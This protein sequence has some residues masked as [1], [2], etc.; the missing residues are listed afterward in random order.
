MI[1]QLFPFHFYIDLL[2]GQ[3]VSDLMNSVCLLLSAQSNE[4]VREA[5]RCSK[6]IIRV[7]PQH[8]LVDHLEDFVS[9]GYTHTTPTPHP[10]TYV[11]MANVYL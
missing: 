9:F 2:R 7:I 6:A 3:L 10:H 1:A 8:D 5:I 11:V 4:V